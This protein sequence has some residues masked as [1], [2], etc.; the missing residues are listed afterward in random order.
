MPQLEDKASATDLQKEKVRTQK[1]ERVRVRVRVRVSSY[2]R[3]WSPALEK[4]RATQRQRDREQ[5]SKDGECN[6]P[7]L[8][9]HLGTAN[10]AYHASSSIL[11]THA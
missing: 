2:L 1:D 7:V 4:T 11:I 3:N 9:L 6:T 5:I 10:H 8:C